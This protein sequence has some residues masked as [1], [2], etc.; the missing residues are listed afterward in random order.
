MAMYK[1]KERGFV[2]RVIE[3]GEVFNYDGK[4]GK[5]MEKIESKEADKGKQAEKKP[6]SKEAD[7]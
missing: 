3:A 4:P 5:W 1:A 2:G 6:E 7:K